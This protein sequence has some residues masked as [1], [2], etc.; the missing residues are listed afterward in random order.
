MQ[1]AREIGRR[2][3]SMY[4]SR[5]VGDV[6]FHTVCSLHL[7]S[8]SMLRILVNRHVQ[9]LQAIWMMEN[10]N[11]ALREYLL[12]IRAIT[13]QQAQQSLE[14]ESVTKQESDKILQGT[15]STDLK[16]VDDIQDATE[17]SHRSKRSRR[18]HDGD[19]ENADRL[20][21]Q[22]S[23]ASEES[24]SELVARLP[25]LAPRIS[26]PQPSVVEMVAAPPPASNMTAPYYCAWPPFEYSFPTYMALAKPYDC[27]IPTST[28]LAYLPSMVRY[29]KPIYVACFGNSANGCTLI[30][31]CLCVLP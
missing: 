13:P 17:G 24:E 21:H 30:L 31:C 12:N 1:S 29:V 23:E 3:S 15:F 4:A 9:S 28:T 11:F 8:Q 6:R 19:A 25:K 14:R 20:E 2:F 27:R 26:S 22:S 10:E 7:C 18:E 5:Y 16:H